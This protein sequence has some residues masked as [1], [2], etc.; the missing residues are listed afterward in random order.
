MY[1]KRYLALKR[2]GNKTAADGSKTTTGGNL[3]AS[4]SLTGH[5]EKSVVASFDPEDIIALLRTTEAKFAY[6][7]NGQVSNDDMLTQEEIAALPPQS[8]NNFGKVTYKFTDNKLYY[9]NFNGNLQKDS[10]GNPIPHDSVKVSCIWDHRMAVERVK[11]NGVWVTRLNPFDGGKPVVSEVL[12]QLTGQPIRD[13]RVGWSP[14]ERVAS[15]I[16]AQWLIPATEVSKTPGQ[17]DQAEESEE[18]KLQRLLAEARAKDAQAQ[19]A[20]NV[21]TG[22]NAQAAGNVQP[23]AANAGTIVPPLTGE[24]V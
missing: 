18:Q 4:V 2:A 1:T 6:L 9:Y 17:V 11:E 22:G 16:K 15:M 5:G 8:V 3:Y 21:Q 24:T 13:Y 19:A 12:D 14:Q 10:A 20:G 23:G 7:T